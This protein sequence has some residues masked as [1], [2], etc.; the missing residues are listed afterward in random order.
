MVLISAKK[1]VTELVSF[2]LITLI[3][4]VASTGAYVFS[5]NILEED[6]IEIDIINMKNY[7]GVFNQKIREIQTFNNASIVVDF[8]FKTG[9]VKFV[10]N[11][12]RYMSLFESVGGVGYCFDYLC[13]DYVGGYELTY[14]NLSNSYSFSKNVTLSPGKYTVVFKNLGEVNEIEIKIK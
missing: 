2:V 7:F 9:E 10:N 3:I 14:M 11:Q 13:Y 6:L 8:S 1:A 12:I 4:V 5:K